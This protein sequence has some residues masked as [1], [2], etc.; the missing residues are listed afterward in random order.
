MHVK[1][2]L[3]EVVANILTALSIMEGG[4]QKKSDS[5]KGNIALVEGW[6]DSVEY[7]YILETIISYQ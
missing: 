7:P 5:D 2:Y 4:H 1:D 6:M 3:T